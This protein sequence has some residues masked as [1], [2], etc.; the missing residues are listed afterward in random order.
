MAEPL[1]KG[2]K[3]NATR[4]ATVAAVSTIRLLNNR[5]PARVFGGH[6]SGAPA[7]APKTQANQAP[8]QRKN[9]L[10]VGLS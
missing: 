9:S 10:P 2:E 4:M 8:L 1:Y 7:D 6:G 5:I 3:K